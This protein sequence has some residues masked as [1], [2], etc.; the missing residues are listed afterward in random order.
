[1]AGLEARA[2]TACAAARSVGLLKGREDY[3][4]KRMLADS[5]KEPTSRLMV[6]C[7]VATPGDRG[8]E[9]TFHWAKPFWR[10]CRG[11]RVTSARVLLD[12]LDDA[13][14]LQLS[15]ESNVE[16][17]MCAGRCADRCLCRCELVLISLI[18][19]GLIMALRRCPS[20]ES[21]R[22]QLSGDQSN[23]LV[24]ASEPPL[25]GRPAG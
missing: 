5:L 13:G 1:M 18:V 20:D 14:A 23:H 25:L 8:A 2:D 9:R 12:H 3:R 16:Q 24:H 21:T 19:V 10:R 15:S 17:L 22:P 7:T 4:W 6:C 11:C